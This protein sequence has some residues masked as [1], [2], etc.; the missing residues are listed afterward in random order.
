MG[1]VPTPAPMLLPHVQAGDL[2]TA[3]SFNDVIDAINGQ[4]V[5][6]P[7]QCPYC[8]TMTEGTK[9]ECSSCR[10]ARPGVT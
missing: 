10:A 6:M 7:W 9:L 3:A 1:Y 2:M 8:G 5:L 4:L